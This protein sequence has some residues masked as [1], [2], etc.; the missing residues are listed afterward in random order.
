MTVSARVIAESV[1]DPDYDADFVG[2]CGDL[3][4]AAPNDDDGRVAAR[5]VAN[6]GYAHKEIDSVIRIC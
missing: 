6:A 4:V 5:I 2:R 3:L 1:E